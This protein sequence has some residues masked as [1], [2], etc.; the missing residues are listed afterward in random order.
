MSKTNISLSSNRVENRD[1]TQKNATQN[2]SSSQEVENECPECDGRM[3]LDHQKKEYICESC[4]L[5]TET[6]RI[7]HGPDWRSFNDDTENKKRVGAPVTVTMHDKG[8]STNISWQNRDAHGNSLSG[9]QRKKMNRLRKWNKRSTTKN[10]KDRNLKSA[11]NEINRMSSAL[12]LSE[13]IRETASMVYRQCL[14]KDL[15]VGRSIEGVATASL[16]VACRQC[17][18]PRSLD[19]F[20]PISRICSGSNN[21]DPGVKE[22]KR[23]Y[24]YI[25]K[26]LGLALEPVDPKEYL[27]RYISDLGV[28][29]PR[30]IEQISKTLIDLTKEKNLHSG[31]SPT[32]IASGAI[33]AA[34]IITEIR[35]TQK[36]I[37]EIANVSVVTVRNHY[38]EM[39]TEYEKLP[40]KEKSHTPP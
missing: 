18:S 4:G 17:G 29:N 2:R 6:S 37:S 12:G 3:A 7:D 8:L 33:Y 20:Y 34:R 38:K 22:F 35:L 27:H 25:S 11:L 39:L 26:E 19:D 30:E 23:T 16:Y 15:I 24:R 21:E 5:V 13:Q 9:S 14:N 28:E 36:E 31:K 32:S 10:A 1:P 40:E